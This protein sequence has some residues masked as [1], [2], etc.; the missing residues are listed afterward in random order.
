MSIFDE[1]DEFDKMNINEKS[2]E[3]LTIECTHGKTSV[4]TGMLFCCDCGLE[5]CKVISYEKEWRYYGGGDNQQSSDPNRCFIRKLEDRTIFR[6]VETYGFSDKIVNIANDIYIQVTTGKIYRG[7][8]RKAIVFASIFHATK[9]GGKPYSCERLRNIFKLDRKIILKGLKH[10]NLNAPKSSQIR[11]KYITPVELVDEYITKFD[12]QPDEREEIIALY[13]KIKNKS[14][15]INRSRPQ[16]VT[17]SIIYYY[18]SKKRGSNNF[19]IE[20]FVK[21]AKLSKLTINKICLELER[22]NIQ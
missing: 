13:D 21:K 11:A 3:S 15:I 22:I 10:V 17:S 2:I 7:N 14:S 8:S 20:E 6:D 16:S 9:I 4:E 1:F 19:C 5:L 18:L 12:I